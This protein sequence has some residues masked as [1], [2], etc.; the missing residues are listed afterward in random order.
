MKKKGGGYKDYEHVPGKQLGIDFVKLFLKSK[1]KK[2]AKNNS[3]KMSNA[4]SSPH[5]DIMP[6]IEK[7]FRNLSK[8]LIDKLD[9]QTIFAYLK[10]YE[11]ILDSFAYKALKPFVSFL[12]NIDEKELKSIL[13]M[14]IDKVDNEKKLRIY[15]IILCSYIN[16]LEGLEKT[17]EKKKFY[18]V[19][20]KHIS[21]LKKNKEIN[22]KEFENKLMK[23][24]PEK[25]NYSKL[26]ETS[27]RSLERSSNKSRSPVKSPVRSLVKSPVRSPVKSPVRSPM[28]SP[29]RSPVRSPVKSS[30]K[31]PSRSSLNVSKKQKNFFSR[32]RFF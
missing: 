15:S 27:S 25:Y 28:K 20:L 3:Y 26:I 10:K 4:R 21:N 8:L 1:S 23:C 22:T 17:E 13:H 31:Y 19:L 14:N 24:L 2:L 7:D 16:L 9:L 29:V 32:F 6:F 12:K 18:P 11:N 5:N 30:V